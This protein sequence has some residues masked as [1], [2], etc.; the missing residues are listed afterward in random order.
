M[1]KV[2][3]VTANLTQVGGTERVAVTLANGFVENL[4]YNV[5]V[6]SLGCRESSEKYDINEK[7]EL[8]YCNIKSK[9]KK[10]IISIIKNL[11]VTFFQFNKFV[12]VQNWNKD[13]C[14]IIGIG[15][16]ISYL[17]PY[18]FRGKKTKLIG[19]QH[20]PVRNNK[21]INTF[22]KFTLSKLTY[23]VVLDNDTEI[24]VNKKLSLDNVKV[25]SNPL[26]L[27]AKAVSDIVNKEVLAV[28]RLTE[29]KG[30][31]M[32]IDVWSLVNKKNN[33]WRLTIVGEGEDKEKLL[34]KIKE[35]GLEESI[36]IKPFTNNISE[37][38]LNSSI[39][40]LSSRYEG[41][42]LVMIEAQSYG[43]PVVA[44]DCP[45]GPRNIINNNLDG[46]LVEA[47]NIEKMA[48]YLFELINDENKRREFSNNAVLNSSKFYIENIVK[49][50]NEII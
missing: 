18:V 5:Q 42:G 24:E 47:N 7:I 37:Y 44:F 26:P 6:V 38:Y 13:E 12:K 17:L 39:Y 3:I 50:W 22:R 49:K 11:V 46:Y 30:F 21:I 15:T 10:S 31:D 32:L 29:Q 33:E 48:E 20:N 35:Y 25:I 16:G 23:Y 4:K 45:T 2:V 28:G 27:K 19:T 8:K 9:H 14:T 43:L 1:K 34:K 36:E 40:V 41:F